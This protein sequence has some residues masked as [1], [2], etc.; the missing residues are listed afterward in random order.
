MKKTMLPVTL[1]VS[2]LA[3]LAPAYATMTTPYQTP[4]ASAGPA[5]AKPLDQA[6]LAQLASDAGITLEQASHLTLSQL[7]ALKEA[8]DS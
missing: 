2:L 5:Q 3:G 7:A 6:T 1:A 4:P 8:H